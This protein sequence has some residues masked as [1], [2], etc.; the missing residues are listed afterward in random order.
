MVWFRN[1][2]KIHENLLWNTFK[3][4]AAHKGGN[5]KSEQKVHT[6]WVHQSTQG[7]TRDP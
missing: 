4:P 2:L 5:T 7:G 6:H 3:P 1:Y